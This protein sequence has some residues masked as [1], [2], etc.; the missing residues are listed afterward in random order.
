MLR[1]ITIGTP[2]STSE[3]ST[4]APATISILRAC[5]RK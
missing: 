2:V 1:E 3:V 5:G 4:I